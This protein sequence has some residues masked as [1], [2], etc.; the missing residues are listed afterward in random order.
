MEEDAQLP[1]SN[2]V[3]KP[4][5]ARGSSAADHASEPLQMLL[6]CAHDGRHAAPSEE[7]TRVPESTER[8]L[9]LLQEQIAA[10]AEELPVIRKELQRLQTADRVLSEMHSRCQ[11]L[12][13]Q[14]HEREVLGPVFL[15]LIGIADRCRQHIRRIERALDKSKE[16]DG[17]AARDALGH[18][19]DARNADCVE[20]ENMLAHLGVKP[21]EHK[22]DTFDP[23]SQKCVGRV[24]SRNGE[25][26]DHVAAR[27]L[28]G[29][30]RND[31]H[32]RPEYVKVYVKG[33]RGTSKSGG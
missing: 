5:P 21:F 12:N 31:R 2:E 16:A 11:E 24:E 3:Q 26:F 6:D 13:E 4:S 7:K 9:E 1:P 28:P 23:R 8:G 30:T 33:N 27:V 10:C 18:L 19:L 22:G 20:L 15:G 17:Q 29:Y 25:L 14:F 32:V